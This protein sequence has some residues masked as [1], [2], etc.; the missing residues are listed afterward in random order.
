MAGDGHKK[1]QPTNQAAVHKEIM[2]RKWDLMLEYENLR[3]QVADLTARLMQ[4]ETR[5]ARSEAEPDDR[6]SKG[7]FIFQKSFSWGSSHTPTRGNLQ[8]EVFLDWLDQIECIFEYK[9][10][11]NLRQDPR[12]VDNYTEEFYQLM[13]K[14][15][16]AESEQMVARYLGGLRQQI[17]DA[18]KLHTMWIVKEAYHRTVVTENQLRHRPI[19]KS[20]P[21]SNPTSTGSSNLR[22]YNCNEIGHARNNCKKPIGRPGKQLLIEGEPSEKEQE[23]VYDETGNEEDD[24]LLFGESGE[25]LVILGGSCENIISQEAVTKLNLAT[26]KH[27]AVLVSKREV[28]VDG[29]CLVSFS[30]GQKYYDK[31]WCDVVVMDACYL[32]LERPWQYDHGVI[33]DGR[34]NIYTFW[35]DDQK[36]TLTPMKEENLP[37]PKAEISINLLTKHTCLKEAM[38]AD[39]LLTVVEKS[40]S[41]EHDIPPLVHPILQKFADV[42]SETCL[43][44]Y[45]QKGTIQ[46]IDFVH[47]MSLPNKPTYHMS[48]TEH[49]LQR[50]IQELLDKG[51]IRPSMSPCAVPALLVS[52]DRSWCICIDSRAINRITIKYRFS[53]PRLDD[54]INLLGPS[55]TLEDH[56]QHLEEVLSTLRKKLFANPKKCN[57][58]ADSL[59]F[60]GYIVSS[61]GL[62]ADDP[63]SELYRTGRCRAISE[64]RS[65]HGLTSFYR[66]FI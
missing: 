1:N 21:S 33:H 7:E 13:T 10:L 31:I 18:L 27:Q 62:R 16:L 41:A 56:L 50:Q 58:I 34:Q 51:Y 57:F 65:F 66:K 45:H 28:I 3:R 5:D 30:I 4:L 48:P 17:Q 44:D 25:A 6:R 11:Q 63:R 46:H 60:L 47:G 8:M 55:P 26:E 39:Y 19:P 20:D 43:Q 2:Q 40:E 42:F 54:M 12:S 35:K 24:S 53:I 38:E 9:C 52:K 15:D 37:K 36:I 59:T 64:V 22:C 14:N 61:E 29:R 49:E 32:L 23:P